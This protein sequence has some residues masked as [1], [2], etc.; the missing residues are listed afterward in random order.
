M[1]SFSLVSLII[2]CMSSSQQKVGP[3]PNY[4]KIGNNKMMLA[5]E[6]LLLPEFCFG[7]LHTQHRDN[8]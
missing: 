5:E 4:G 2:S 7:F 8:A 1:T 3:M 6:I